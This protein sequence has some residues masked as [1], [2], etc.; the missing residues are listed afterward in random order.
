MSC[1]L[2]RKPN[3]VCVCTVPYTALRKESKAALNSSGEI[4]FEAQYPKIDRGFGGCVVDGRGSRSKE[5]DVQH[6]HT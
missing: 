4:S 2:F 6:V 3:V 5:S 1:P